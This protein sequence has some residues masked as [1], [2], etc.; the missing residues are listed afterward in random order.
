MIIK[1][2]ITYFV[3]YYDIKF[4]VLTLLFCGGGSLA[5]F[6]KFRYHLTFLSLFQWPINLCKLKFGIHAFI[7]LRNFVLMSQL[8][9]L[10]I[11]ILFRACFTNNLMSSLSFDRFSGVFNRVYLQIYFIF[12]FACLINRLI[13]VRFFGIFN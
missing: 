7:N 13:L 6:S 12:T 5:I 1:E 2:E 3:N 8:W 9:P 11:D 4:T 10:L